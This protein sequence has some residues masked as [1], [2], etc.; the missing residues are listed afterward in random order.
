MHEGLRKQ[1][2]MTEPPKPKDSSPGTLAAKPGESEAASQPGPDDAPSTA[3]AAKPSPEAAAQPAADKAKKN[4][5]KLFEAEK[6]LRAKVEAEFQEYRSKVPHDVDVKALADRA[7]KAEKMA[8]DLAS[9]IRYHNYEKSPEFQKDFQQPYE[10]AFRRAMADLGQITVTDAQTGQT[11]T[12]TDDDL[13]QVAFM[14]LAQARDVTNRLFPD[15]A[16]DIMT[17]RKEIRGLWDRRQAALEE[18]KGKSG[19]R[20]KQATEQ[21][22][23]FRSELSGQVRTAW[24]KANADLMAH[25]TRGEYFKP[26]E[27]DAEWNERLEKGY[28]LADEAFAVNLLDRNMTAEQRAAAVKRYAAVRARAAGWGPLRHANEKLQARVTELEKEL[29]SYKDTTP[30]AGG[31]DAGT[32]RT[33]G[34][35]TAHDRIFGELRRRAH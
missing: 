29:K 22:Q 26:R 4:P 24:E 31:S 27:G 12:F 35:G 16:D 9:E 3:A 5:W 17:A 14:N 25:E 1:A 23:K 34:E 8:N 6:Q 10:A 33:P 28:K 7:E 21:F 2:E 19:D 32:A 30:P 13:V 18:W 15:Y 20:A 11:R